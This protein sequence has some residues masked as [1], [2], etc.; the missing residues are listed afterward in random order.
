MYTIFFPNIQYNQIARTSDMMNGVFFLNVTCI[1]CHTSRRHPAR[2][3]EH[4]GLPETPSNNRIMY[5]ITPECIRLT[6]HSGGNVNLI[7]R[8]CGYLLDL[9]SLM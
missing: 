8:K 2:Y 7:S 5:T 9:F 3:F 6:A 1:Q 4:K